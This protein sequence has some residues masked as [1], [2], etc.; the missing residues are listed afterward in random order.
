M[1]AKLLCEDFVAS[2]CRCLSFANKIDDWST[3]SPKQRTAAYRGLAQ[4]IETAADFAANNETKASYLELAR[5]RNQLARVGSWPR[6]A[7]DFCRPRGCRICPPV[8]VRLTPH[9]RRPNHTLISQRAQQGPSVW[10][11]FYGRL[12]SSVM[13]RNSLNCLGR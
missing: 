7:Y 13:L 9:T 6:K 12:S 3:F 5:Q 1:V 8:V 11:K 10:R 4:S 2:N